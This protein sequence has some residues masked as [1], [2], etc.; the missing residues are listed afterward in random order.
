[1]GRK[2]TTDIFI[3]ES[4]AKHGDSYS[5]DKTI[6]NSYYDKVVIFCN[7]HETYFEQMPYEHVQ[8]HGCPEC[9]KDRKKISQE[10]YIKQCEIVHD[11]KYDY[12]KVI[13]KNIRTKIIIGCSIHGDFEQ[14][15]QGH[16]NGR[17]CPS[18][19]KTGFD[20]NSTGHFYVQEILKD[21]I[22]IAYKFG[23]TKNINK[24]II[25]QRS[26]SNLQHNLLFNFEDAG[27]TV[28]K[29]EQTIKEKLSC[30][31]LDKSVL[32]DGY[33]ETLSPEDILTLENI[34]MDF[35]LGDKHE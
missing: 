34:I 16:K 5:Y 13:Y 23:I 2:I 22:C 25:N 29:L 30:N 12:S 6:Y 35:L 1:M 10:Q 9:G 32:P 26:K 20:Y 15:A 19:A 21:D 18:C 33:T 27:K 7:K 3:S 28:F 8:G 17:G 11:N 14:I 24:R 31:Y 4:I